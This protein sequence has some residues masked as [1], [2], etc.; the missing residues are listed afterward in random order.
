MV[1]CLTDGRAN[2]PLSKALG[3]DGPPP[4]PDAPKM[5]A[6]EMKEEVLSVAGKIAIG[7]LQLLVIDTENKF[8]STGFAKEVADKALVRSL[9]VIRRT[10]C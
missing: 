7:G 1:V 9:G 6:A 3:A 8:L 10:R 4:D 2:V 5:T